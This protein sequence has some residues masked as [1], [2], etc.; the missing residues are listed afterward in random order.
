MEKEEAALEKKKTEFYILPLFELFRFNKCWN[1]NHSHHLA[2]IPVYFIP[3]HE[4]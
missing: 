4:K 2:S 1:A 3:I